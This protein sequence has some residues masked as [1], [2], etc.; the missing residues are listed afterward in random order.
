MRTRDEPRA[1]CLGQRLTA[2]RG[3]ACE[4]ATFGVLIPV[5]KVR[6]LII[7]DEPLARDRL[8]KFLSKSKEVEL[9]GE[10]ADGLEAIERIQQ[11]SP[12][13]IFLD[14]QMPELDGFGVLARLSSEAMPAVIFVT[15]YDQ[16]A[17]KAFEVHAVDYLL[18]PFDQERFQTALQRALDRIRHRQ[19]GELN[20]RLSDLLAEVRPAQ[21][22]TERLAI[23]S[24]GRVVFIKTEDLD[25]VESADNYVVLHI[26]HES[27]MH[28]E[29]MNAMEEQLPE[30][31]FMRI[32]R[33]TIVN[34]DR[35]KELQ[36]LFHGEYAVI[37]RNGTRLTLSR[38]YREKLDKLMG[39]LG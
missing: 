9:I 27:H 34:V 17:L 22:Q 23:K 33:S 36:P 11:E 28:R 1:R 6:A 10:C 15:A 21:K 13:L 26:G 4:R 35:I 16:F 38:T 20:Q 29:T 32:S 19:S 31:K 14:V 5:V 12:D 24:G 25:W 7:D 18:K 2:S 3:S 30:P 8:R 39:R 37:L